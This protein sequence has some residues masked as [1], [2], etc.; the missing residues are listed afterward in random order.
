MN[1]RIE[2]II[3]ILN[4]SFYDKREFDDSKKTS[5]PLIINEDTLCSE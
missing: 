4:F 5:K 1:I 2:E 3:K